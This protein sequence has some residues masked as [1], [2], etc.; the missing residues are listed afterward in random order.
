MTLYVYV[1]QSG[2]WIEGKRLQAVRA[3][4]A[5]DAQLAREHDRI[6]PWAY[7]FG[8]F[9]ELL[10]P[11]DECVGRSIV[12]GSTPIGDDIIWTKFREADFEVQTFRRNSHNQEKQ[13]DIALSTLMMEDS[14]L[15]MDPDAGD[16]AVLVAGDADF[17]PT[18]KSLR[19][20][21]L[22][23]RVVFWSHGISRE[24]RKAATEVVDLDP[25]FDHLTHDEDRY[26]YRI[27]ARFI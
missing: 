24:L 15:H 9:Y 16:T 13:V 4:L 22:A 12:F 20:R 5:P 11:P 23:V 7:N 14:F 21:D 3:G 2:L 18:V 10:C 6:A 17:V 1:D 25:H 26:Q 19:R 27:R 8:R